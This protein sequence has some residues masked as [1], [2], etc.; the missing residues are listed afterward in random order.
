MIDWYS[1]IEKLKKRDSLDLD[2]KFWRVQNLYPILDKY[3]ILRPMQFNEHQETLAECIVYNISK[4]D[5]SPIVVLKARQVGISTFCCVWFLDDVLFYMGRNAVI[6][7]Y[8]HLSKNVIFRI[9]CTAYN[10]LY[11]PF[12]VFATAKVSDRAS[13]DSIYV[14]TL[15]SRIES[16]IQVRSQAVNM[17]LFSE[18]AMMSW[19]NILAT[20]G[21]LTPE[22]LKV[23][24]STAL[25]RNHLY[26]FWGEQKEKDITGTHCIF[27]PWHSHK[28][29]VAIPPAGGLKELDDTEQSLKK[30]YGL[31]DGQLEWRRQKR[32]EISLSDEH[33]SFEQEFPADDQECFDESGDRIFDPQLL[34][35]FFEQTKKAKPLKRYWLKDAR[36][37]NKTLVKVYKEFKQKEVD[38]LNE[39]NFFAFYGGVDP[40]EGVGRDFS[41]C[42]VLTVNHLQKAEVIMTMRGHTDPTAFADHVDTELRR[43]GYWDEELDEGEVRL[44]ILNVERNNH[45][46]AVLALLEPTYDN[47][48]ADEDGELGF[49]QTHISRKGIML[50]LLN[51]LRHKKIT[52]NDPV[53]AKELAALHTNQSNGKIEAHEGEHDDMVLALALALQGYYADFANYS[54]AREEE[55]EEEEEEEDKDKPGGL[56]F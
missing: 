19:A 48:Y 50:N 39:D 16:Q 8:Q 53:L 47:L 13:A 10:H 9:I 1:H 42:I 56:I 5:F 35:S 15:N 37:D 55:E 32:A 27:F 26:K 28:A 21:S 34:D 36:G 6:Q 22:C 33:N 45:G 18:Y 51:M 17:M 25:G 49:C 30:K 54:P 12:K 41:T 20:I 38:K 40:A 11:D 52:L 3:G 24:E 14:P 43:Y 2:D 29:Y 4:K 46:H 7:S 44:P 31:T 23:Y